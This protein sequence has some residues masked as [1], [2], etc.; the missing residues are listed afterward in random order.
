MSCAASLASLL[1]LAAAPDFGRLVPV[2]LTE[3]CIQPNQPAEIHWQAELSGDEELR[4]T[5][6]D[7]QGGKVAVV[8]LRRC[9]TDRAAAVLNCPP[10]FYEL[11]LA[12]EHR[13]GVI[14]LPAAPGR[15]D[16]F[17]SID[18]AMSWLVPPGHFADGQL[19]YESL[20][21][22][23][24]ANEVPVLEMFHNAP[25]W[26]GLVGRYPENLALTARSWS[27]IAGRWQPTWGA[28]EVWNEPDIFFGANLPAD[29][30]VAMVRTMRFALQQAD[31][32]LP[33]VTGVFAH[34]HQRFLDVAAENGLLQLS[35]AVSFHTYHRAMEMQGLVAR[36]RAWLAAN[37]CAAMPLWITESGR[38]W[39]R[40]PDRPPVDQDAQSAL[41]IVMKA[42]EARAC[43]VARYFA[44]VY[45]FYEENANNFGMMGREGTPL[46]SMA[47]YAQCIWTIPACFGPAYSATRRKPWR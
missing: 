39:R 18:A 8:P 30:Y 22:L 27:R 19:K 44:F 14:C 46:R 23:Y 32:R 31:V 12:G 26:T 20:R 29:Q 17:F 4:A 7:Y 25:A 21:R 24:A 2:D 6:R 45:P 34:Y 37:D 43:G 41:D 11:E 5:L 36:Y 3:F 40:G 1:L 16:P 10:G 47:A 9:G 35:D 28:L 13:F 38:P 15:R 33:L 42:V